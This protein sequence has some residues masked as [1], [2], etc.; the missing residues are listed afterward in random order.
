MPRGFYEF[1]A[2]GG[3]ARAGLGPGWTCRFAND[4]D[5]RKAAIYRANWGDKGEFCEGDVGALTSQDLPGRAD[6]MWGSFPCQDLSVAGAGAGLIGGRSGAFFPF[7]RLVT[8]LKAAGRAPRIVAIENVRGTLTA[9]GGSDFAMICTAFA[10]ADYRFGALMIDAALFTPQSRPRLFIV[11]VA[12][13][14]GIASS[15]SVKAPAPPFH[16]PNLR[17]AVESLPPDVRARSV[18]W[19]VPQP[20]GRPAGLGDVLEAGLP[21]S[22]WR[23]HEQT[24]RLMSLM[25]PIHLAKVEALR[26]VGAAAV[27][28]VY[29]RTRRRP[30]GFKQ[31]RAE[32]RFDGLAGCLRTPAGGS[33]RQTLLFVA[34]GEVR[35]R[36]MTPRETARLMGL[37]DDYELPAGATDAYHLTGDGVVVGVVRH[38]AATL[39][40]PLL[41]DCSATD[42]SRATPEAVGSL[43]A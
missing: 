41:A 40:E 39:F 5:A 14:V 33:S 29:R 18:W 23:S 19:R 31:Q 27:G 10:R 43:D 11:G 9:R 36:L 37:P 3:M 17:R 25:A 20:R 42:A 13:D 38:L 6:L 8:E 4:F 7:W 15:L 30:D 26:S 35:S 16:G 21:S 22:T 1:F 32:V 12:P 34:D 28:A 2:G 24:R